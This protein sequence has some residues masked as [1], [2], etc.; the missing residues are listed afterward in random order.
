MISPLSRQSISSTKRFV[1]P[2]QN[3]ALSMLHTLSVTAPAIHR[4][5]QSGFSLRIC[6][7]RGIA[8]EDW[9]RHHHAYQ[10]ELRL[11]TTY[12]V[13]TYRPTTNDRRMETTSL[14]Q[15]LDKFIS[16]RTGAFSSRMGRATANGLGRMVCLLRDTVVLISLRRANA[17]FSTDIIFHGKCSRTL[18]RRIPVGLPLLPIYLVSYRQ[19][20]AGGF[21]HSC[22]P[23]PDCWGRPP[24]CY[25]G[26]RWA[27]R[28]G[29][30]PSATTRLNFT[31]PTDRS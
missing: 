29:T 27:S 3:L 30:P 4:E 21:H 26:L 5:K 17:K 2:V 10:I 8:R 9:T 16:D 28:L 15:L 14:Q 22:R 1:V 13:D 7:E 24:S 31:D 12:G 18:P 20:W 23:R 11:W 19:H 6:L 25:R